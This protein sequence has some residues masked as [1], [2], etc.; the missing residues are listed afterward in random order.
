MRQRSA[1]DIQ[2]RSERKR[3]SKQNLVWNSP[4]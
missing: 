4:G 2:M 3:F 1:T